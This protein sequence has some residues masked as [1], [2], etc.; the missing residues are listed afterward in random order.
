MLSAKLLNVI[1]QNLSR[2]Q[3]R[4]EW[5]LLANCPRGVGAA[6]VDAAHSSEDIQSFFWKT[7]DDLLPHAY[8]IITFWGTLISNL[9]MISLEQE[10]KE[11]LA[12]S[13]LRD[14]QDFGE[15]MKI[16]G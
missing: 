6:L 14:G 11:L 15:M 7:N 8:Q 4:G 5:H 12:C 1:P 3:I 13:G 9:R 2:W 10:E 16:M